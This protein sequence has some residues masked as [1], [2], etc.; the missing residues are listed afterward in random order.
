MSAPMNFSIP[1]DL[2]KYLADLDTFIE[3]T[4]LPL[5]H[6]DDNNRFGANTAAQI[7]TP[8]VF[9]AKNGKICCLNHG[10]WPTKR[11]SIGSRCLSSMAGRIA[12]MGE[13][14]ICGWLL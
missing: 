8:A 2:K 4:I 7:G 5:Q 12:K 1:D 3:T 11:G 9:H 14:A 13:G 6:K 10:G